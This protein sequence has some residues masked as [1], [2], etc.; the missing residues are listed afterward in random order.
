VERTELIKKYL[1]EEERFRWRTDPEKMLQEAK[2]RQGEDE[3]WK[4]ALERTR[5]HDKKKKGKRNKRWWPDDKWFP[6]ENKFVEA[7]YKQYLRPNES[8]VLWFVVRKTWGWK[9]PADFIALKQFNKELGI[10]KNKVCEALRALKDRKIVTQ[11]GNKTYAIQ[12]D[13]SLWHDRPKKQHS[14]KDDVS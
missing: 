13:V 6:I 9:H 14:K 11:L 4:K 2:K 7:V 1:T 10:G 12:Q 8:K 5:E 3:G